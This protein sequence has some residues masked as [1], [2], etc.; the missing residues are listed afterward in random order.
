[1]KGWGELNDVIETYK[2]IELPG[3]S[4]FFFL[5][6]VQGREA[7]EMP[8]LSFRAEGRGQGTVF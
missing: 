1:M 6:E 4:Y 8:L 5:K 3:Y 7:R 2:C